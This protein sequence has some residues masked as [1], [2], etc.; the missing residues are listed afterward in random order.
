MNAASVA[1]TICISV[2]KHAKFWSTKKFVESESDEIQL[3]RVN[4]LLL[5]DGKSDKR[6]STQRPLQPIKSNRQKPCNNSIEENYLRDNVSDHNNEENLDFEDANVNEAEPES[7]EIPP[8]E[9][10]IMGTTPSI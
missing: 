10:H 6:L 8:D 3:R 9:K 7:N 4:L 1:E 2:T 5:I